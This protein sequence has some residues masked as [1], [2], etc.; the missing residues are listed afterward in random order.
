M[1]RLEDGPLTRDPFNERE[2]KWI[3]IERHETID[4]LHIEDHPVEND[5]HLSSLESAGPVIPDEI[6]LQSLSPR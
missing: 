3:T 5:A 2:P 6:S 4:V 1:G